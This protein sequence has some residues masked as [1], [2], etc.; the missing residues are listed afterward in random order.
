MISFLEI[1]IK[2]IIILVYYILFYMRFI[3]F[4]WLKDSNY[5]KIRYYIFYNI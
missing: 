1:I 4:L 5:N 2:I 3:Y